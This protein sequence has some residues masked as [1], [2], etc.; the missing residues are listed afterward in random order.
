[1]SSR[2]DYQ[3]LEGLARKGR[4]LAISTVAGSGAGHVGG[5]FSAMDILVALY[6]RVMKIRSDDP[7]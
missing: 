6:F 5:P 7:K 3:E 1:M 2:T 4:W